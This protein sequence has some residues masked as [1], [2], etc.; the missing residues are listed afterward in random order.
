MNR[1]V[2]IESYDALQPL[3][4]PFSMTVPAGIPTRDTMSD[5]DFNAMMSRGLTQAKQGNSVPLE[6]AMADLLREE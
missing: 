3:L 4:L 2:E 5:A 6:A 1:Y